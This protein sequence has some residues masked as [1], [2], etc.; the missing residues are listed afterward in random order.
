MRCDDFGEYL[1]V[2]GTTDTLV[3]Y[4]GMPAEEGSEDEGHTLVR[5]WRYAEA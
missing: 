2:T 5:V 4:I 1:A 3:T